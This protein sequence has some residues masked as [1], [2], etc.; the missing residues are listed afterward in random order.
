MKFYKINNISFRSIAYKFRNKDTEADRREQ[1]REFVVM[2]SREIELGSN[3]IYMD[4]TST[5][6][7]EHRVKTW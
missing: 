3:V 5:N 4:E 7:W 2:L 1:Q 6:L